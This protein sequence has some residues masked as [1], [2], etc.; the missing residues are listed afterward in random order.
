M[1]DEAGTRAVKRAAFAIGSN[2]VVAI[3]DEEEAELS[4]DQDAK[5]SRIRD[6]L[7]AYRA[8]IHELLE[9][10]YA[11]LKPV[12]PI[13]MTDAC[14]LMCFILQDGIIV[15]YDIKKTA[16]DKGMVGI[17]DDVTLTSLAPALSG[18]FVHCP[19]D[20]ECYDPGENVVT[21]TLSSGPTGAPHLQR[22]FVTHSLCAIVHRRI[23][24]ASQGRSPM[25]LTPLVGLRNE[26][27][28]Q[29]VGVQMPED[30]GAAR[31]F[32]MRSR[33][34]L[35][36]GWEAFEVFP[37]YDPDLWNPEL[38]PH[39][40]EADLLA[41]VLK[42]NLVDENFRDIDPSAQTRRE[43]AQM[44]NGFRDLLD[45]PEE[46]IHQYIGQN[47][48]LLLPTQVRAWSK[49]PLGAHI[50]DFVLRDASGDYLLVELEKASHELFSTK[51]K[52]RAALQHAIDQTVDW[53]RYLEDNLAT[54]QRE[55]A[56]DRISSNPRTLVV[57]GRSRSLTE[58]NRRKLTAMENQSPKL[59]IMTYD[60]LLANATATFE[61]I[62]GPLWDPGPY[63]EVYFVPQ[64]AGKPSDTISSGKLPPASL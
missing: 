18:N 34:R 16:D 4:P 1:G 23:D 10:K 24:P 43:V 58:A 13:Y 38:A 2:A 19:V 5:L 30:G 33:L 54:A 51:G 44:L 15:R 57:I 22:P 9:G 31:Q 50:T 26:F 52:P 12:A 56:L 48:S 47:P 6:T 11:S 27:D 59:K 25:R 64:T 55:L 36:L 46:P 21:M 61:N 63:A 60:D 17:S 20:A 41:A 39:W 35:P 53:K 42:Q 8:A 7:K 32:I 28:L 3:G 45:G 29:L 14:S 62:L 49:L 37:Q 40:A